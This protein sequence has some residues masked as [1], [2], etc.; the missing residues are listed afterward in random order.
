MPAVTGEDAGFP[1]VRDEPATWSARESTGGFPASP[2]RAPFE[3]ADP[4]PDEDQSFSVLRRSLAERLA[5][6]TEPEGG[7]PDTPADPTPP[8]GQNSFDA[9]PSDQRFPDAEPYEAP[10]ATR[11]NPPYDGTSFG[12]DGSAAE[13][14][15]PFATGEAAYERPGPPEGT[16]HD[17]RPA[18]DDGPLF[19]ETSSAA[20][21]FAFDD[22]GGPRFGNA[23]SPGEPPA[24]DDGARGSL[25]ARPDAPPF[26]EA[27]SKELPVPGGSLLGETNPPG[28]AAATDRY[29]VLPDESAGAAF[30]ASSSQEERF[31]PGETPF[32]EAVREV[33]PAFGQA[34]HAYREDEQGLGAY[35]ERPAFGEPAGSD[36]HGSFQW[37]AYGESGPEKTARE[38]QET[39]NEF[40]GS[41]D[42]IATWDSVG[43]PSGPPPQPGK[44]SSGNL[45]M[46]E[47]MKDDD[48]APPGYDEEHKRSRLPM[49]AG[50]GVLV[51]GLLTAGAVALMKH[52]GGTPDTVGRAAPTGPATGPAR[53]P[54]ER[55]LARFRGPH[56]MPIGRIADR[57][58]GL[59]YPRLRRPWAMVPK[60]S[61]MSEIGFSAGQFAVT[62]RTGGQPTRWGRLMSAQL[63]GAERSAYNGPGTERAAALQVAELYEARMYAFRH[64]RRL[65]ASQPL[66]IGGHRGWLVGYFLTYHRPAVRTTSEVFTVAVVDTGRPAPGVLFMSVPNTDRRLWPDVNYVVHTL[67]VL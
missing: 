61:P 52:G 37:P 19:G 42:Q 6:Y 35:A 54:K 49:F 46:P 39:E 30:A 2:M 48:A 17:E 28:D 34:G 66:N 62:E 21:R 1:P 60:K 65:L 53:V 47:W 10:E 12:Q 58:A 20:E 4:A 57:R 41:D 31:A 25:F 26:G 23:I 14:H 5:R 67:R 38:E 29:G 3:P 27:S 32:E 18:F 33:P 50:I 59:S 44:P 64:K 15:D 45:R 7:W 56:T 13:R 55:A 9:Q 63:G 36:E 40:F 22:G 16:A 43:A 24:F 51:L 11:E 8:M